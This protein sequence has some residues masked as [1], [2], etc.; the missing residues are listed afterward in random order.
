MSNSNISSQFHHVVC[1][2]N[3]LDK[4]V[5]LAQMQA[6]TFCGDHARSVLATMLQDGQAIKQHLIDLKE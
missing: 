4:S 6:T 2:K 1:V 5:V 3:I